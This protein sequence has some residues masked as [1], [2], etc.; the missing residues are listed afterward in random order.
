[1]YDNPPFLNL[2]KLYPFANKEYAKA[3]YMQTWLNRL[4]SLFEW[5]G[6]PDTLPAM[7]L[8]SYLQL[9]GKCVIVEKDGNLYTCFGQWGGEPGPYYM[10][11]KFTVANPYLNL[12]ET[13]TIGEGCILAKNDSMYNGLYDLLSRY[14]SMMVECDISIQLA[15]INSRIL[16]VIAAD[17]DATRESARKYLEDVADGKLGVIA[18]QPFL[19]SLNVQPYGATSAHGV[20]TDLIELTQYLKAGLFNELGLQANYNMKRESINADEAQL[21]DDMLLPLI[22]DMLKCRKQLCEDVRNKW[23]VE[24]SV[25]FSSAWEDNAI[26]LEAE[27]K[28]IINETTEGGEED[29][30]EEDTTA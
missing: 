16:S 29:E 28:S 13:Y 19:D 27:Q 17:D 24:W 1:M 23:G 10:P 26:E 22:D 3:A 14:T 4:Q 15:N 18:G 7:W 9:Y 5:Q 21:N 30:T 12:F 8:E 20:I 2:G 11:Q 25:E 6:L